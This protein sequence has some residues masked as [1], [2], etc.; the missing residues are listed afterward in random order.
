M[1]L[2]DEHKEEHGLNKCLEAI[3]LPK[4]TYYYRK[5]QMVSY[6]KKY[7]HLREPMHEI[8]EENADY[9]YPRMT[10]EL[11][12]KGYDVGEDVVSNLMDL[13]G[14]RLMNNVDKPSQ[15]EARKFIDSVGDGCNI[16]KK[17]DSIKPLQVFYTDYTEIFFDNGNKKAYLM[18][19]L[20]HS[21]KL[22]AGY[23]L[24]KRKNTDTALKA[25]KRAASALEELGHTL[26]GKI[27][28][29]DQD[30]VYTGYKWMRE[31]L[32]NQS[33]RISYSENGARGNTRM[34]S[35]HSSLK[36]EGKD[37]FLEAKNIW[38]LKRIV[39]ERIEYYNQDRRHSALDYKSPINYLK[40]EKILPEE[41]K[42]L[43]QI[44]A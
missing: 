16:V 15:S 4:S 38:E 37:L 28:H 40:R 25:I 9:G 10:F 18:A 1:D 7:E 36:R 5:N 3:D 26:K 23:T 42:S 30:P 11:Q 34:E 17:L 33:A 41:T 43:A 44:G 39:E 22:V 21:G 31:V 13:F 2:V 19:L 27:I 29:H 20:D 14:I 12:E 6:T 32:I 24:E 35:F 8:A